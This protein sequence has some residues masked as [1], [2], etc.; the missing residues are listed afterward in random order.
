MPNAR[1]LATNRLKEERVFFGFAPP[2]RLI[3]QQSTQR[4]SVD[5]GVGSRFPRL[6]PLEICYCEMGK[7]FRPE[8]LNYV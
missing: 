8:W 7:C 1:A 4:R 3:A 6:N 2:P 5:E